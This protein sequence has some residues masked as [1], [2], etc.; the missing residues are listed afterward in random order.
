MVAAYE[1]LQYQVP[2]SVTL[3]LPNLSAGMHPLE[4][5]EELI[6]AYGRLLPA[7]AAHQEV[8]AQLEDLLAD[9]GRAS[10]PR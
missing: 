3:V 8:Q 5:K 10:A 7:G 6:Q 2:D 9:E 4:A 1:R